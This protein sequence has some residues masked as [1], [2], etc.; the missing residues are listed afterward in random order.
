MEELKY[1]VT[2]EMV[3]N[4]ASNL[5]KR[6][7][8]GYIDSRHIF[9]ALFT[10]H[11]G[12]AY[13]IMLKN[14]LRS[15]DMK[16]LLGIIGKQTS[17]E[18]ARRDGGKVTFTDKT[19]KLLEDAKRE[20][21]ALKSDSVGTAHVLIM[22]MRD[23]NVD[24]KSTL[25]R[26]KISPANLIVESLMACGLGKNEA[27]KYSERFLPEKSKNNN[28]FGKKK[29]SCLE[30][31]CRD[32]TKEAAELKLDP[33]VGR[34][35]EILRVIQILGRRTKN[36]AC[37][38]GEPGVGK[39]AIVEGLAQ[40]IQKK[41]VPDS[42][43]NL[44]IMSLDLSGM[45]AGTRYR[46]DFEERLKNTIDELKADPNII[47]FIDE[48][49]SLIGA[50]GAEGTHDAANIFKPALSRGELHVIGATTQDEYRKYIEKD[51]ALERRFQPVKV[52]EPTRDETIEMLEGLSQSYQDFH[53]V[54]ITKEAIVSAVDMSIRYINDRFLPDKAIDLLDEACSKVKLGNI[55][56]DFYYDFSES[57]EWFLRRL[58]EEAL[59][60]GKIEKAAEL[61]SMI[62]QK[63]S[64]RVRASSASEKGTLTI[65]SDD[66]ADV[67]ATWTGIPV[68]RITQ[69]EQ[70]KLIGL[71]DT[72]HKRIVG[73]EE[74]VRAIA[75]A[76][77]RSRAGLRSPDK[78]IGSFLFL[79]PTGVGKTELSKALAEVLFGDEKNLIRVDMSEYMEKHNV[80]KMIGSPPGYVGYDEGGQ[81]SEQVRRNPYSVVLFDEVEKAHPDVFNVLLQVLDDGMITDAQGRK[82]NFKNTIIIMTSNLGANRIIDPKTLG[83]VADESEQ[84][85]YEEMKSNVME[86]VKNLFKPEFL[87]RLDDIIVFKALGE[88]EVLQIADILVKEL[89]NRVLENMN[90]NLSYGSRLT[91]LI[92]DKGYDKKY[93]AR[94]LRRALQEYVEDP[95]AE[96]ILKGEIKEGD[97]VSVSVVDDKVRF[98]VRIKNSLEK[99]D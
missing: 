94:P 70:S 36:N 45:I 2:F 17:V 93:G 6:L 86:E 21:A 47:L 22:L 33:V 77:R 57:S 14:G 30:T 40:L 7:G 4:E 55:P 49:H 8:G 84:K 56:E 61:R 75:S 53:G 41:C 63:K 99:N 35:S 81:L 66:I 98:K 16:Y 87:N 95:M 37:L 79:G 39:T 5:A 50:G 28:I 90:V 42:L 3:I 80:S 62:N 15:E 34:T 97:N 29:K 54:T 51:A 96:A 23:M 74:A 48:L 11:V 71:E 82:V 32:L 92:F 68:A 91:K 13:S 72:L 44:K 18:E 10:V 52:E 88:G 24:I 46:G 89:R 65:H 26:K 31:Y 73:Q 83:F 25:E 27:V 9:I 67:V 38:V 60:D 59:H 58:M 43:L 19:E 12:T 1:S 69:S 20:A 76:I 64:E 85:S 78:P